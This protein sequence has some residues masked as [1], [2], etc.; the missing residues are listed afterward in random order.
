M[1]QVMHHILLLQMRFVC[2]PL[3]SH[4]ARRAHVNNSRSRSLKA[5]YS[6][7]AATMDSS[8]LACVTSVQHS[9]SITFRAASAYSFG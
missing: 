8:T 3:T 1:V 5:S 9:G 2:L 7:Y 4:H 6:R